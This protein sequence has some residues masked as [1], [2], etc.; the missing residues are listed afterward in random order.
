MYID[1]PIQTYTYEKMTSDIHQLSQTYP[2]IIDYHSIGQTKYGRD[3]WAVKLG[4]GDA[5][6]FIN[7]SHHA[8]EW[9]TTTLNM[10]MIQQ[11]ASAYYRNQSFKNY[12][13]RN[14]LNEVA[15]WFVPMVNPDGVTLQQKGLNALPKDIHNQVLQMNNGS[16]DFTRWKANASGID[17]NRNYPADWP[18][19]TGDYS[20]PRWSNH[21]GEEPFSAIEAQ[22]IRDFTYEIDPEMAFAYHTTGQVLYWHHHYDS[23]QYDRDKRLAETISNYTG[24][25]IIPPTDEPGGG[26]YTDWFIQEYKRPA[27]TVELNPHLYRRHV[28]VENFP[29]IWK[30]NNAVPLYSAQESYKMWLNRQPTHAVDEKVYLIDQTQLYKHPMGRA[31]GSAL[32]PQ[33]VSV[34]AKKGNWLQINTWAGGLWIQD[35][36]AKASPKKEVNERITLEYKAALHTIPTEY[37]KAT[38]YLSPQTV[39]AVAKWEDWYLIKTWMGEYWVKK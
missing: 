28:P 34:T 20:E 26:T 22:L 27:F 14:L 37:S 38:S 35:S 21:K 2:E 25:R 30:R 29:S 32:S 11:Y 24:Y 31:T 39:N 18:N 36:L 4:N 13:V 19:I 9:I 3:L 8:R 1:N 16:Y 10:K 6:V 15:I 33:A 12:N 7:G 5:T 23:N 17:L